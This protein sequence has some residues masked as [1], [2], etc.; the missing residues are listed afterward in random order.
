MSAS[1]TP[2]K[3]TK[4]SNPTNIDQLFMLFSSARDLLEQRRQLCAL[5]T[6]SSNF[7][8]NF[9]YFFRSIPYYVHCIKHQKS[10]NTRWKLY[11]AD[12]P[13]QYFGAYP[14]GY[15]LL[16]DAGGRL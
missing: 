6:I 10:L 1:A 2:L 5:Y 15:Y 11:E 3:A 16:A 7:T 9:S 14:R 4:P 12:V 8:N 13:G